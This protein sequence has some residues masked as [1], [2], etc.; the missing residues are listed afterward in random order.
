MAQSE[1]ILIFEAVKLYLR[2]N[3]LGWVDFDMGGNYGKYA[4]MC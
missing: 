3:L 1:I 2:Q 4:F